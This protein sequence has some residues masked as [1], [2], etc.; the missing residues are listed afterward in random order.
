MVPIG[1]ANAESS[2]APRGATDNLGMPTAIH[3]VARWRF[4]HPVMCLSDYETLT[5]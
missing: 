4:G 1:A 5:G 3:R 2:G